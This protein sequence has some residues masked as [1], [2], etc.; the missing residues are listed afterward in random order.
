MLNQEC[1]N[2][3]LNY[4]CVESGIVLSMFAFCKVVVSCLGEW[5]VFKSV[6]FLVVGWQRV[7]LH[8]IWFGSNEVLE[9]AMLFA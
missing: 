5:T 2:F 3:A 1:S 4:Q 9:S 8:L 7:D 6:S